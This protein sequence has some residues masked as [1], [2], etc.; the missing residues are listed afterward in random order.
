MRTVGAAGEERPEILLSEA[1]EDGILNGGDAECRGGVPFK[2]GTS[3]KPSPALAIPTMVIAAV[4]F[5]ALGAHLALEHNPVVEPRLACF[6]EDRA[7]FD[8]DALNIDR[9][10][11]S[12]SKGVEAKMCVCGRAS[13]RSLKWIG[14]TR[15]GCVSLAHLAHCTHL[16]GVQQAR[17]F[18][19]GS[20]P[21][22]LKLPNFVFGSDAGENP[23]P[24][25]NRD[26]LTTS[27]RR[28][29]LARPKNQPDTDA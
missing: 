1:D 3:P 24:T 18:G 23:W 7:S 12:R 15:I 17:N 29:K 10:R 11:R 6:D 20:L 22:A 27:P 4:G 26:A 9:R 8:G 2:R 25:Q 19:T 14:S 13:A 5:R 21:M 16:P 28:S